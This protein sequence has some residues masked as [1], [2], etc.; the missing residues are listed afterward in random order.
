MHYT[1]TLYTDGSKFDSSVDRNQPFEFTLGKGMV[2][3]GWDQGLTNMCFGCVGAVWG[4]CVLCAPLWT[5]ARRWRVL[6]QLVC[7][8]TGVPA[9][10]V[11]ARK[12]WSTESCD[13]VTH[14]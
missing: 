1:G 9:A 13:F 6:H 3:K 8:C 11:G 12:P 2:I 5:R 14:S 10:C 7:S 4:S